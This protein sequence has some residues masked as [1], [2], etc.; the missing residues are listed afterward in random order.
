MGVSPILNLVVLPVEVEVDFLLPF[1]SFGFE[2]VE[3]DFSANS[4]T[5]YSLLGVSQPLGEAPQQTPQRRNF[6]LPFGS[7]NGGGFRSTPKGN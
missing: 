6:L 2:Q 5:F 3:L 4:E 1:G 7:F